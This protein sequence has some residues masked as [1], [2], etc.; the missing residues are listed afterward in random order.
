MLQ[1]VDTS[2]EMIKNGTEVP[3]DLEKIVIK[4]NSPIIL[5]LIHWE[6]A[7]LRI[8]VSVEGLGHG[9]FNNQPYTDRETALRE[10]QDV[11]TQVQNGNYTLELY[12]KGELKL[13]LTDSK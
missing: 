12:S 2:K 9:Y 11:L 6:N 13:S 3:L 4:A 1:V 10:Y 7:G 8:G 5:D